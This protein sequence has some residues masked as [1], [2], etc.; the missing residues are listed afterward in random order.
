[1]DND[2]VRRQVEKTELFVNELTPVVVTALVLSTTMM[3]VS[4][5]KRCQT[6]L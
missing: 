4:T 5:I 1:M 6:V 3:L 2:K